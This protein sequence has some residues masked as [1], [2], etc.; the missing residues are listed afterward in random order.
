MNIIESQTLEIIRGDD[1]SMIINFTD[2]DGAVVDITQAIVFFTV[3][4]KL[5]DT[6]DKAVIAVEQTSHIT[7]LTGKTEIE[8]TNQQ[9]DIRPGTYFYDLQLKR[10]DEKISSIVYGKFQ[11][12][13]DVTERTEVSE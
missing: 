7:P 12:I 6:D 3:K 11:V 10:T 2:E 13:Q 9:T 4:R 8:L 5:S 1:V